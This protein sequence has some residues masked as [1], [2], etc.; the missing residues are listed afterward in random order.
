[1]IAYKGRDKIEK[2]ISTLKSTVRLRPTFLEKGEETAALVF[3]IMLYLLIYSI[4]EMLR[5]KRW[6]KMTAREAFLTFKILSI[7]CYW[8]KDGSR[9]LN[10]MGLDQ[11]QEAIL[12]ALG[13]L[14]PD[15][16]LK[17]R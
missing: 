4:I 5:R 13:S 17:N 6:T 12:T 2:Q 3:V 9:L 11:P 14:K 15:E 1:M 7:V 10:V 16:Y 8:F